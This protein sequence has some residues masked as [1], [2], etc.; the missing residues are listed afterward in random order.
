[1]KAVNRKLSILFATILCLGYLG[2][3]IG[4][5]GLER[6]LL[7][8]TGREGYELALFTAN[9]G[10]NLINWVLLSGL[11]IVLF[12]PL[13]LAHMKKGDADPEPRVMLAVWL[14]GPAVMFVLFFT[15]QLGGPRDWDLFSLPI[16]LITS[17]LL[18]GYFARPERRIP[19][20]ILPVLVVGALTTF[21]F[22]YVNSSP[23]L[24]VD[25]F[26]Q[27]LKTTKFKNQIHEYIAL[28]DHAR[29]SPELSDHRLEYALKAWGQPPYKQADSS[30][31]LN[32][33]HWMTG[34][35]SQSGH[36][37]IDVPGVLKSESKSRDRMLLLANYYLRFGNDIDRIE[38]AESMERQFETDVKARLYAGILYLKL[39]RLD[40]CL[41]NLQAAHLLD[42]NDVEVLTAYAAYQYQVGELQRAITL[43]NRAVVLNPNSFQAHHSLAVAL[44]DT[45]Q[46]DLAVEHLAKA[47]EL[48]ASQ[49]HRRMVEKTWRLLSKA[50][51][52][53]RSQMKTGRRQ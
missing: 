28:M 21:A 39:N 47:K 52:D 30:Y 2:R 6:Q 48:A 41:S 16:F 8:L 9:H 50:I 49:S 36:V 45:G 19:H 31:V 51:Q 14:A 17:A 40:D 53:N 33:L 13:A 24:S 27:I 35:R 1:V 12:L 42:S 38:T 7:G 32:Y 15:P 5:L 10:W 37:P 11:P 23:R 4:W 44:N 43:L 25:R 22:G 46:L 18:I 20:Q 29:E 3:S 34:Y 26:V